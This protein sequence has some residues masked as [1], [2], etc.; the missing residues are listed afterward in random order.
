MSDTEPDAAERA[1]LGAAL[2]EPVSAAVDV[3]TLPPTQYLVMEVLAARTRLGE[4]IWPFPDRLRPALTALADAGL[5]S[6]LDGNVPHTCRAYLTD[7]GRRAALSDIYRPPDGTLTRTE[8]DLVLTDLG[9]LLD[10]LGLGNFARP[11]S[12]HEVFQMCLRKLAEHENA[13]TWETSCLSC[14]RVLDRSYAET[15]RAERAEAALTG[16]AL[17]EKERIAK[18]AEDLGAHYHGPDYDRTASFADFLRGAKA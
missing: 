4:T 10:M 18:V 16:A 12:P 13:I 8:R 17:T 1:A 2:A 9:Q 3:D 7:A 5:L 14:A 6:R 11:Q 15:C